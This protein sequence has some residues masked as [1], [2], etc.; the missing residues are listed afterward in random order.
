MSFF[1]LTTLQHSMAPW[2]GH[3]GRERRAP[4][5]RSLG[6]F[7][8]MPLRCLPCQTGHVPD[9]GARCAAVP[10]QLQGSCLLQRRLPAARSMWRATVLKALPA[11]PLRRQTDQ[12]WINNQNILV[13]EVPS[14]LRD[15]SHSHD[16]ALE[17]NEAGSIA[18]SGSKIVLDAPLW[19]HWLGA[20]CAP[21][22]Q[23]VQW[24]L[25]L[26]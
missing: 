14:G 21:C 26:D 1:L 9:F 18:A 13:A 2:I 10:A 6:L 3:K 24:H 23:H 4:G 22:E 11:H 17:C 20:R 5:V 19:R 16:A 15:V 7:A 12:I 8:P 25:W